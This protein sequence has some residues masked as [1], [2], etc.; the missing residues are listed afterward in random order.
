MAENIIGDMVTERGRTIKFGAATNLDCPACNST[1]VRDN[2]KLHIR[3]NIS[4]SVT[5][6]CPSCA[7]NEHRPVSEVPEAQGNVTDIKGRPLKR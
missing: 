4:D 1:G 6:E 5:L 7:Y 3:S 2:R